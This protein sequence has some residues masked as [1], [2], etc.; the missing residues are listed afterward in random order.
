MN[1][2]THNKRMQSDAAFGHAAD[3]ERYVTSTIPI[4]QPTNIYPERVK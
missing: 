2:F 4:I 3:A 1:N